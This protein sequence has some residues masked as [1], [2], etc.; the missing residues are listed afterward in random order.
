MGSNEIHLD[1][2][3]LGCIE[4]MVQPTQSLK[5]D[6]V[7]YCHNFGIMIIFQNMDTITNE[8]RYTTDE[9]DR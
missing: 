3:H 9:K 6:W 2:G 1:F 4:L 8:V 7:F 5:M